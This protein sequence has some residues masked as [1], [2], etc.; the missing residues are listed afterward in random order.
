MNIL[1]ISRNF[2]PIA[3]GLEVFLY[4]LSKSFVNKGNNV[5]VFT[6]IKNNTKEY[7]FMDGIEVY[8]SKNFSSRKALLKE[9]LNF[10]KFREVHI[11][12]YSEPAVQETTLAYIAKFKLRIPIVLSLGGTKT[13]FARKL[14]KLYSGLFVNQII[15]WTNYALKSY[16]FYKRKARVIYPGQNLS[17]VAIKKDKNDDSQNIV[18]SVGRID[19]R[20][21]YETLLQAIPFINREVK[22]AEF[23]VIGEK[24]TYPVYFQELV[25]LKNSLGIKNIRFIGE[26]LHKDLS[27]YYSRGK[28]FVLPSE[29]EMFGL[30]FIEAMAAGL[31][32]IS[33]NVAAIPEVVSRD[34]GMLIKPKDYK[35]LARKVV[36]LLNDESKRRKMSLAAFERSKKFS[37]ERTFN[38]YERLFHRL[39]NS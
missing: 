1:I 33:T 21:S 18:I 8:R 35:D 15:G 23:L 29:H 5:S 32:I 36:F 17:N 26:V 39:I 27:W 16:G 4:D 24:K 6:R 28:I 31:P 13:E 12:F 9:F 20:K 7:E 14:H 10:I 25:D 37:W 2:L 3:G 38:D 30:V 11:V 22:H 34:V 19:P